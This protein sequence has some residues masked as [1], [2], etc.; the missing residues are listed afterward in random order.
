MC[1]DDKDMGS[2][3]MSKYSAGDSRRTFLKAAG[4]AG[5][6]GMTGLSG[7]LFSGGGGGSGGNKTINILTWEEY[8]DLKK[9]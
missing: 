7:C 9:Q 5:A 8:A 3:D 4:T 2:E 6:V 1:M